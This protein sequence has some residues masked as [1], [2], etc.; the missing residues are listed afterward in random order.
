MH[1]QPEHPT[2]RGSLSRG[3]PVI[4]DVIV[5]AG[6]VIFSSIGHR[7]GAQRAAFE[8]V[9]ERLHINS[10]TIL[11]SWR[12]RQQLARITMMEFAK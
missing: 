10:R 6:G 8:S 7:E 11:K 12:K 1:K 4:A 9:D 2:R 3:L 5:N